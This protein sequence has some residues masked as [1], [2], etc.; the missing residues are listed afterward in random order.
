MAR[1]T[2]G[3]AV[4]EVKRVLDGTARKAQEIDM[5]MTY[6]RNYPITISQYKEQLVTILNSLASKSSKIFNVAGNLGDIISNWNNLEFTTKGDL[7]S[8][9]VIRTHPSI[10]NGRFDLYY[11][12]SGKVYTVFCQNGVLGDVLE[13][14]FSKATLNAP[15]TERLTKADSSVVADKSLELMPY[16]SIGSFGGKT[17]GEF[18]TKLKEMVKNMNTNTSARIALTSTNID[19]L[20]SHW[21]DDDYVIPQGTVYNTI[22]IRNVYHSSNDYAQL[23]IHTFNYNI[24]IMSMYNG[25]WGSMFKVAQQTT[26]GTLRAKTQDTTDSSDNVATTQFVKNAIA[27]ALKAKG[28]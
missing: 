2:D 27:E 21:S 8:V 6:S 11:W 13:H 20:A 14:T 4:F 22:I 7:H 16:L 12:G 15:T 25:N 17:I 10:A 3:S 19:S 9:I 23:L 26:D 1:V 24:Y 5:D 28:L 18:K